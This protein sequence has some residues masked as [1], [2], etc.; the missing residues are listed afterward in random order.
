MVG[1]VVSGRERS[2]IVPSLLWFVAGLAFFMG[3]MGLRNDHGYFPA[4]SCWAFALFYLPSREKRFHATVE[5]EGLQ[6]TEPFAESIPF[7]TIN[8]LQVPS[9]VNIKRVGPRDPFPIR[10]VTDSRVVDVPGSLS[11]PSIDF[12]RTVMACLPTSGCSQ[13]MNQRLRDYHERQKATFGDEKIASFSQ[14]DTIMSPPNPRL[15]I[16]FFQGV[17]LTSAAWIVLASNL[18]KNYLTW[19]GLGVFLF[20]V[21]GAILGLMIRD[22]RKGVKPPSK[23]GPASLVIGPLGMA[24]VQGPMVGELKWGEIEKSLPPEKNATIQLHVAGATISILD[25][26][27]RPIWIIWERIN[28]N[29][30]PGS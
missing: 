12:W 24:M 13:S 14:R 1:T 2:S 6:L 23:W 20:I 22:Q 28:A 3:A 29:L 5:E 21:G 18:G 9:H 19:L 11:M 25:I 10:I 15:P 26:Y 30:T 27:D 8:A 16:R 7:E 17:L 4:A